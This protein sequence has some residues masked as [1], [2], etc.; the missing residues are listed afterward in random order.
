MSKKYTVGVAGTTAN[1]EMCIEALRTDGRFE[2]IWALT[3]PPKPTGRKQ[4]ITPNP[5][6]KWAETHNI[7]VHFVEKKISPELQEQ[8]Q[9]RPDFLLVVDFGYLVPKWLLEFPTV[10]P[11][12]I[13]PSALPKWRGSSPG[14]FVL[15]YGEKES[16]QT[17]MVMGAGMDTGPIL[18]QQS[19][20]VDPQW[21]QAEYYPFSFTLAAKHLGD[22]LTQT[23]TG[24]ITPAP[25]PESSPTLTARRLEKE[26]GYVAWKIL[27]E[28]AEMP[29]DTLPD[30]ELTTSSLLKEAQTQ[31][32][33][34]WAQIIEQASRALHPW[35][36]LWTILPTTKGSKRMKIFSVEVNNGKLELGKVQIEGQQ[37]AQ[38]KEVQTL[39]SFLSAR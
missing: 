22:I 2:V 19:F 21:T 24:E 6:H 17:I 1:T 26:D 25:Q 20:P 32:G 3:P 13:H 23:E 30:E 38:W 14:Q 8:L 35:P 33:Q 16:A 11:V 10:A 37:P 5:L 29:H 36:G 31:T 4:E 15:L 34:S 7:P 28:L 39:Y 12:N 27:A 18:W 9:T